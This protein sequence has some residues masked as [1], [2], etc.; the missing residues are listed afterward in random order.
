M[1]KLM[2]KKIENGTVID[3]IPPDVSLVVARVL[4]AFRDKNAVLI[5]MNVDSK[6]M[7]KKD[8]LKLED[9]FLSEEELNKISLLIAGATVNKIENG[10]VVEKKL[11]E[12]PDK[13]V[14]IVRC[15]NSNCVTNKGE[16]VQTKFYVISKKPLLLRCHYCGRD[17]DK[18]QIMEN[19]I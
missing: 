3:H 13:A 2:V 12:I 19:V 15:A 5:A 1:D 18:K 7:G 16:P 14:G 10:E 17:M 8:I 9:R 6:R 11:V 4:G